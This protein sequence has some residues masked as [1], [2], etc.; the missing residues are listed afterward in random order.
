MSDYEKAI[1]IIERNCKKCIVPE[2]C[3]D[4]AQNY[5]LIALRA[6]AEQSKG[7]DWCTSKRRS[8]YVRLTDN[9]PVFPERN[10]SLEPMFCPMCG[11]HMK[12]ESK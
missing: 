9:Y 2:S 8:W 10:D 11:R 12:E 7:C 3:K 1:K 4:C 6:Q 5:A